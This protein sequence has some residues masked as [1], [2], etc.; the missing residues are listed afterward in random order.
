MNNTSPNTQS[1]SPP[2]GGFTEM[3]IAECKIKKFANFEL[4]KIVTALNT[5]SSIFGHSY[6]FDLSSYEPRSGKT[7]LKL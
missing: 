4:S 7:T 5:K 1:F 2:A 6:L 3:E